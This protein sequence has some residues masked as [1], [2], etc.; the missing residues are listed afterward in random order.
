MWTIRFGEEEAQLMH[1]REIPY[2]IAGH[3][4][5]GADGEWV[6]YDLQT[7]RASQFWIAGVNVKTGERR[8]YEV[9]RKEWSVHYNVSRDGT[10]F[11][12][13]GGGP[14]SVANQTP[15]PEKRRLHPPGNG[16]WIY[17]FRPPEELVEAT[18][19]G[20]PALSGTMTAE[21]LVDLSSHDY[22]LEP[23]VTF[24][25]DGKWVVFRSNMHGPRHV[26]AVR[27]RRESDTAPE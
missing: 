4:F 17:L 15:L 13:D 21:R 14:E 12:G 25:P 24:T 19:S 2:E 11:A 1:R 22:D 7:P 3:E 5:F 9:D 18:V 10:L 23:N 16:Q 6:W 20:E 27:V 26:Y 8:R